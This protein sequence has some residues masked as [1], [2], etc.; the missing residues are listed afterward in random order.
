MAKADSRLFYYL[1]GILE[2]ENFKIVDNFPRYMVGDCGTVLSK[3]N[4]TSKID[5]WKP[6]VPKVTKFGRLE[7]QLFNDSGRKM[8]LV[9]RLVLETFVGPCPPGMQCCHNDGDKLNNKVDN[10]R[11]D[12]H[13]ANQDDKIKHGTKLFGE[14]IGVAKLNREQV[15]EID[16]RLKLGQKALFIAQE[17]GINKSSVIHVRSGETWSWLTGRKRPYYGK[18]KKYQKPDKPIAS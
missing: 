18:L 15:V 12:T 3:R 16:N 14:T 2:V 1:E 4:R 8:K 5:V 17:L 6:L 10:L 13:Q 9:H 11:W 7:V